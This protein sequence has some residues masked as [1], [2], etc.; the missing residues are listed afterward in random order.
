MKCLITPSTGEN[1]EQKKLSFT[2][3]EDCKLVQPLWKTHYSITIS[4]TK[5]EN[6]LNNPGATPSPNTYLK[7]NM[8]VH[9]KKCT[10]VYGSITLNRP[11]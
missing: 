3:D 7:R 5:I 1:A 9:Q 2:D 4:I 8:G 10:S 6:T 11:N